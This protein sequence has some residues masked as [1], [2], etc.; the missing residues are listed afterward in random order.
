MSAGR[1]AGALRSRGGPS[2][3]KHRL[4]GQDRPM[5]ELTIPDLWSRIERV[6]E[7]QAAEA[8]A[9]LA[10]PATD[11]QIEELEAA[12]GQTL[13]GDLRSSLKVHDGQRDPTRC[14]A[15][16]GEG[17]LLS[18]AEIAD[19]WKMVTEIDEENRF[20]AAPGQG[21]WW[22]ASCIPFT[23]ADGNML[24]VDMDPSLGSRRGEVVCHVHDS[25][26]ERGLGASYETWLS[27][28]VKRLEA[29]RFRIDDYGY[30]W[31]ETEDPPK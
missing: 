8:A 13:P 17:M 23:D 14:H 12:I 25:E 27:S 28:L 22:K 20:S 15:F 21:P 24:C 7:Q 19:R 30:L 16:C 29:G 11:Q 6:L 1:R 31:L 5:S 26:I 4:R 10:G 2:Y 9:T 18:V 3:M